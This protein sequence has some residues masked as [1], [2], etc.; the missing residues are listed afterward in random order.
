[1]PGTPVTRPL[2]SERPAGYLTRPSPRVETAS[3]YDPGGQVPA[4]RETG[5]LLFA[6]GNRQAGSCPSC[7]EVYRTDT[8]PL[9]KA[10]S[11][12]RNRSGHL[13]A[14]GRGQR[15]NRIQP[16]RG[17]VRSPAGSHGPIAPG[18]GLQSARRP[19]GTI[20]PFDP[21]DGL[22]AKCSQMAAL[23]L[24]PATAGTL[25]ET[26]HGCERARPGRPGRPR[27]HLGSAEPPCMY[28]S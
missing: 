7:S 20:R 12:A 5:I 11:S 23:P 15:R 6:C 1:M 9:L 8:F 19:P 27:V 4:R 28:F 13:V 22:A 21:R 14:K 10:A 3:P 18:R 16:E 24:G 25:E 17:P 2:A 26:G